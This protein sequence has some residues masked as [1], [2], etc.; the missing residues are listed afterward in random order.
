MPQPVHDFY[1]AMAD[2][3]GRSLADRDAEHQ[4]VVQVGSATC[5]HAAGSQAV[6][7]E[8][9]RHIR[10]SGRKDI[11]LH[12]TGCTGR[13]SREP[14]LGVRLP[15]RLPVKY[16]RVNRDLVHRIFTEHIQGGTPV[17]QHVLDHEAGPLPERE[18]LF[19]EGSRCH[20][21]GPGPRE[22]FAAMLAERGVSRE[23]VRIGAASCFGACGLASDHLAS[24]GPATYV[25]ARPEKVLYRVTGEEDLAAILDGHL[26]GGQVVERLRAQEEPIALAF[27]ERYGD[28][29]FFN[30]QSRVALRNAGVVDPESLD[31]Y[32]DMDGFKALADVL[33]RRDPDWVIGE[34]TKAR[35]RGRG[36]GGYSTAAK[37]T[38]ARKQADA[39]RFIICNGDEGDPGA[40]MDRSMLESDPFNIVEGMI[41]GGFA[42]GAQRGFFYIRAEYPLAIRRIQQAIETCR[43]HGLLGRNIM[44]SGWDFDLE[45]RLGAGAFVCGEETALIR[46]I[47]GERGQ[48]RVRPP[49]PTDRGLWDHPTVIN[50]VETFANISAILRYSGDW[51]AR[52]GTEKS[53]GTKVFALAGKVRHT[54]LV[55]VPLGTPLARV[56][57]DIGGGVTGGRELKAIQTGG[58]AGGFIPA[59]MQHMEVDFEPLQKAGSIMGSGGMIVLSEDD[60]MVDIAKFYIA[61]SQDESCGKCTPCREGT[62][63]LLEILERITQGKGELSDLDKLERLARLCQRTSLCGLGRAAPNPVLSSLKHFRGEFLAHI[64]DRHCPAKKCVALIHYEINPEKCVGCTICARNCPVACIA[65]TRKEAHVIDQAACVKCGNCFDVCKFAAVDRV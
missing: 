51:Y 47:E 42:I 16:E 55:E 30:R 9:V 8:L 35:L 57:N 33:E 25:L 34:L 62:T 36:G 12:R 23:S 60:C 32:V 49:Y 54:G 64:V 59:S 63:R 48:P 20:G 43:A 56:V 17:A 29:A 50:N 38:M 52:L 11:L 10:A 58:P 44:D 27:M 24:A 3:V 28:V 41:I 19:C 14:I 15:G 18:L 61:F 2:R 46:S 40:F 26:I 21:S 1:Q 7:D 39:T 31:E 4:V 22:R 65:G 45:I 5:E 6:A 13:C 53:G 37:W